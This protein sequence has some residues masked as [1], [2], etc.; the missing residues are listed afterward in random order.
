MLE[1]LPVSLETE[2]LK[3]ET[4][5]EE[6]KVEVDNNELKKSIEEMFKEAAADVKGIAT[7]SEGKIAV[8][9]ENKVLIAEQEIQGK[10][11]AA[12]TRA[13]EIKVLSEGVST[14]TEIVKESITTE[15]GKN[16]LNQIEELA[17]ELPGMITPPPFAP[18]PYPPP[19]P[20][21][22][23]VEGVDEVEE[24]YFE[25]IPEYDDD[26]AVIGDGSRLPILPYSMTKSV[27]AVIEDVKMKLEEE[28]AT[29]DELF[30]EI[31]NE[32]V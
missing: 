14:I 10:I 9:T 2:V 29:I 1:I 27:D 13:E 23:I 12:E 16:V 8:E 17:L 18:M 11:N 20:P 15:E 19:P 25:P 26:V 32:V 21:V 5:F 24:N 3:T 30:K 22:S 7:A 4:L 31:K 6:I 28:T